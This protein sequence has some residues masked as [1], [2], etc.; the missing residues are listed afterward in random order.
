MI[1]RLLCVGCFCGLWGAILSVNVRADEA[2]DHAALRG[3]VEKY[4]QTIE[5]K[6]TAILEPFLASD[7]SGVMVTGEEVKNYKTLQEYWQ[8]I[9][10]QIGD[11]G[12]YRVKI[13]IPEPASI[14]GNL[15]YAYG[16]SEDVVTTSA[17][18][19]YPFQGKWTAV[20]RKEGEQWKLVRIHGSMDAIQN[21]FVTAMVSAASWTSGIVGALVGFVLGVLAKIFLGRKH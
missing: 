20:C 14:T 17:G 2:A 4:E 9:Q 12:N 1:K 18:K 11:K 19:T 16:T 5:K 7:F 6:D 13:N 15:A 3:L 21:S 8:K 10:A